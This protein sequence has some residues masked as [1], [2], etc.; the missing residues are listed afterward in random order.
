MDKDNLF[1]IFSGWDPI[2]CK[3]SDPYCCH[4]H[5]ENKKD[6]ITYKTKYCRYNKRC[7]FGEKCS[8]IHSSDNLEY[9]NT[10]RNELIIKFNIKKDDMFSNTPEVVLDIIFN[11]L[12]LYEIKTLLEVS[13]K[14]ITFVDNLRII[15]NNIKNLNIYE[16]PKNG[17]LFKNICNFVTKYHSPFT[18]KLVPKNS[19]HK[20][21]CFLNF[22]KQKEN[23]YLYTHGFSSNFENIKECTD[24]NLYMHFCNPEIYNFIPDLYLNNLESLSLH[25]CL[26][27]DNTNIHLFSN[28]K[29]ILFKTC[30]NINDVSPLRNN[31]KITFINCNKIISMSLSD[32]DILSIFR[33]N[34]LN[35]IR[36]LKDI[37]KLYVENCRYIDLSVI[38]E[39]MPI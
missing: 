10:R 8:F 15:E 37:K 20:I 39:Q 13:K 4:I 31:S 23:D 12:N 26:E 32:L 2:F 14:F 33:C 30:P 25:K 35:D 1:L 11:Y 18:T 7:R 5:Q 24:L 38:L 19:N 9:I 16:Y 27:I 36:N 22:Q 29:E 3:C 34:R 17:K 21:K 6:I 28:I